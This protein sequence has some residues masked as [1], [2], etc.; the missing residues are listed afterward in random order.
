MISTVSYRCCSSVRTSGKLPSR[1]QT[2]A[3]TTVDSSQRSRQKP[4]DETRA[5]SAL[6][7]WYVELSQRVPAPG[8]HASSCYSIPVQH[9]YFGGHQLEQTAVRQIIGS[10]ADIVVST[11]DNSHSERLWRL[12]ALIRVFSHHF[13]PPLSCFMRAAV[14]QCSITMTGVDGHA[15]RCCLLSEDHCRRGRRPKS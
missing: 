5:S 6:A 4:V 3:S 15:R 1:Q 13:P 14:A 2:V 9:Q 7:C 8:H 10:T 11:A 12:S